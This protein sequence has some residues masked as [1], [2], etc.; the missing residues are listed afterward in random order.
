MEWLKLG[1]IEPAQSKYNSLIVLVLKKNGGI[2]LVQ[3]FRA[4]NGETHIDKHWQVQH[5]RRQRVRWRNWKIQ[6]YNFLDAGSYSQILANDARNQ[7]LSIHSAYSVQTRTVSMGN[8]ADGATW[9]SG[10]L[11]ENDESFCERTWRHNSIH[12][13]L[14]SAFGH[15]W[16]ASADSGTAFWTIGAEWYQSEAG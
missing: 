2:R 12:Q 1:V 7:Q 4:L 10:Q 3:D 15:I 16:Q 8:L 11:P 13:W 6:K 5:D 9:M 14:V